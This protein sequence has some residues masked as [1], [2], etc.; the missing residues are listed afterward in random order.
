[1]KLALLHVEQTEAFQIK[2]F[3]LISERKV[4]FCVNYV[5]S[6]LVEVFAKR[7]LRITMQSTWQQSTG[8][9]TLLIRIIK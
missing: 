7:L 8:I 2:A 3:K 1:M 5:V 9:Y 4:Y 6:N